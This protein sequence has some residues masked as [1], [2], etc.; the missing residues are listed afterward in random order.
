MIHIIN[1]IA[2]VFPPV[3]QVEAT[4]R[5]VVIVIIHVKAVIVVVDVLVDGNMFVIAV[6]VD[7]FS[8]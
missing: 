8:A 3:V 5:V 7:P 2:A 1:T 4:I 6:D